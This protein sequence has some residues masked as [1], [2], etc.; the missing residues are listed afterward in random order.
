VSGYKCDVCGKKKVFDDIAYI[1]PC[2]PENKFCVSGQ[3][4][5]VVCIDCESPEIRDMSVRSVRINSSISNAILS[6]L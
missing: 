3:H 4:A 1:S 2:S 5:F 6:T